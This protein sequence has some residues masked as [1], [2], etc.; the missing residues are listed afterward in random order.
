LAAGRPPT[1]HLKAT[2]EDE[3]AG[4]DIQTQRDAL[5]FVED[6]LAGWLATVAT[7]SEV[8]GPDQV[9]IERVQKLSDPLLHVHS[10]Q[11]AELGGDLVTRPVELTVQVFDIGRATDPMTAPLAFRAAKFDLPRAETEFVGLDWMDQP[12]VA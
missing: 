11:T 6:K 10:L 8:V 5:S 12:R 7:G 9:Q 3:W 1:P 2:A 4:P